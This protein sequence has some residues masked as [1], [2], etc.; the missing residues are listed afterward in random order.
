MPVRPSVMSAVLMVAVVVAGL[1]V[2]ETREITGPLDV[3]QW[4]VGAAAVAAI[5]WRYRYPRA[6]GV[7]A[8]LSANVSPL[9]SYLPLVGV[10]VVATRRRV[11]ETVLITVL[12]VAG[13]ALNFTAIPDAGTMWAMVLGATTLLV[14]SVTAGLFTGTRRAMVDDLRERLTR[15]EVDRALRDEQARTAER[16]R[17]A[18]EMHDRLGHRL[19]LLSVHAGALALRTDL[20]AETVRESAQVLR[21]TTHR[22]M[23]DL[24]TIV[25]VLHDPPC[26]ENEDPEDLGAVEGLVAEARTA[27]ADVSLRSTALLM[28]APPGQP[29]A[30][31]AYRVVREGLTNAAR[32]SPGAPVEVVLDGRPGRDLTVTVTSGRPAERPAPEGAGTGLVS[33]RERVETL[34]GG[35]LAHGPLPAGYRLRAVLPWRKESL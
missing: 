28:V 10:F 7:V 9:T 5:P 27:G 33:L 8:V 12:A 11:Y 6:F 13:A 34:T 29:L 31:V 20:S 14:T 23:E 22:A 25:G 19:S 1:T 17:I 16:R 15:A 32:H 30:G 24:R 21:D 2:A 35:T 18:G 4:V 26:D 3:L